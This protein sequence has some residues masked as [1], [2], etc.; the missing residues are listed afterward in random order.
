MTTRTTQQQVTFGHPF[1]LP[2]WEQTWPAGVYTVTTDE[3]L[4]DTSF[5]SSRRVSTT[6]ALQKGAE[7]RHITIEPIDLA[8]AL[9]RDRER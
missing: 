2:G 9:N 8:Y 1:S 4:L 7:T 5:P 6:I 3:E